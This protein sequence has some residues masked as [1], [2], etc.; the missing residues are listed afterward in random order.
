MDAVFVQR[1]HASVASSAESLLEDAAHAQAQCRAR[2]V[3]LS[4]AAEEL[5]E[6]A[7]SLRERCQDAQLHMARLRMRLAEMTDTKNAYENRERQVRK[8]SKQL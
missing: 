4:I 5:R 8:L 2:G 3:E 1:A 7:Q 6:E